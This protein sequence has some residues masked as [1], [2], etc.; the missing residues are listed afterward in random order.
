MKERWS[1]SLSYSLLLKAFPAL[2]LA[3]GHREIQV[4]RT[5]H[6]KDRGPAA[7]VEQGRWAESLPQDLAR[8]L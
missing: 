1:Q 7:E 6:L 5:G 4:M 2:G 8:L 3:H